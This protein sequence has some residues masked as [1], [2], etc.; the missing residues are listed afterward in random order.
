MRKHLKTLCTLFLLLATT[1]VSAQEAAE[2][3]VPQFG[4]I[5]Y[6]SVYEQMPEYATAKAAFEELKAKYEAEAK[7]SEEEFQR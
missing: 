1:V 3:R 2:V 5:S 4:Y 6:K 7:H